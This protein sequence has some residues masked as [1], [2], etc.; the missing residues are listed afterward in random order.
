MRFISHFLSG[1]IF[2]GH[3][4][5]EGQNV[6]LYSLIYNSSYMIPETLITLV[7]M[8]LLGF[9]QVRKNFTP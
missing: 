3:Y 5:P 8:I 7:A 4:A 1:A 2:F 6:W 9:T